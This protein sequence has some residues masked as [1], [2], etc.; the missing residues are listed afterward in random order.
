[1]DID[2]AENYI[3]KN[4]R[5][6]LAGGQSG[7]WVYDIGGEYVLK[8]I[9]RAE[10]GND[11][12]YEAYRREAWWYAAGGAGLGCLPEVFDLRS[13]EDEISILMKR[14]QVLSRREI[15]T[16]LLEKIMS[17]LAS[18]HATELPPLLKQE[19]HTAQP[20]SEEQ[21][22]VSVEGWRT[23]LDEHP[24]VFD[25]EPLERIA[26]EIN[27]IIFWHGSEEAVLNHGDFH[28]DN[29]LMDDQG[30]IIICDWQGVGAGAASGDLSFFFGRL[31]GDGI[32]VKE[33]EI[34]E[35]YGRE[36]RRLSGKDITWEEICGHIQ[37]ANVITSFTCW[38]QYLHGSDEGRVREIYEKMVTDSDGIW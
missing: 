17:T 9:Y 2:R 20:L 23:V 3:K 4:E 38:H 28:W 33:Q 13:T 21:I 25:G 18:V 37:A 35:A 7:A 36:I 29:L 10:L 8:Q 27:R 14:Y 5:K 31:R 24:G 1:M 6:L 19:Q 22:R 26:E 15:S 16:E 32:Q 12:L 34:V 30:R 11:E